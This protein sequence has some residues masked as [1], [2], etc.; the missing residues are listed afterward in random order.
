MEFNTATTPRGILNSQFN[1]DRF[2]NAT[3]KTFN[4][5]IEKYEFWYEAQYPERPKHPIEASITK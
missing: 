1:P 4:Q 5:F 3:L 2:P